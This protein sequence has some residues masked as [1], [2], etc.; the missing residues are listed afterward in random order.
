[1]RPLDPQ[2]L[3][4][5]QELVR[6]GVKCPTFVFDNAQI[7]SMEWDFLCE[8]AFGVLVDDPQGFVA[9]RSDYARGLKFNPLYFDRPSR[10][11][12]GYAQSWPQ[13]TQTNLW[14]PPRWVRVAFW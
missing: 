5:Q 12:T 13:I 6:V 8:S 4:Y 1:M 3:G 14:Q 2:G 9:I 7:M 11:K 10:V